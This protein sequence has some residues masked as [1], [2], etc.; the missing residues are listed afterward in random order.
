LQDWVI[1]DSQSIDF[2]LPFDGF[3]SLP[4]PKTVEE[5]LIYKNKSSLQIALRNQRIFR[6]SIST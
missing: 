5:Y 6:E 4:L 2:A 3:N 1:E